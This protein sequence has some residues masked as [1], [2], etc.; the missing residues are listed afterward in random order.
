[1]K[2]ITCADLRRIKRNKYF[3]DIL[4]S[5]LEFRKILSHQQL[6]S[7]TRIKTLHL[8][9][10]QEKNLLDILKKIWL[11]RNIMK[12]NKKTV[13]QIIR[14]TQEGYSKDKI[15]KEISIIEPDTSIMIISGMVDDILY[16]LHK[17]E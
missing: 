17:H 3:Y 15:I 7:G 13:F 10:E 2:K 5:C 16:L 8:L 12:N 4:K 9:D 1:M 11:I 14:M 6:S